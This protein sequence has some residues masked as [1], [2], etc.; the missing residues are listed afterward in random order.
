MVKRFVFF[1]ALML[2]ALFVF[3]QSRPSTYSVVRRVAIAA[4]QQAVFDEL[5]D[6]HEWPRWS[7]WDA[8]DPNPKRTFSGPMKG[9][10]ATYAWDGNP[11]VGKGFMRIASVHAP[12]RVTYLVRF[13]APLDAEMHYEFTVVPKGAGTDVTWVFQGEHPVWAKVIG[14]FTELD[15]GV[16]NDMER[17]LWALKK[18]V[19]GGR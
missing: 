3:L 12:T 15:R 13:E 6:L 16:G 11:Q 7:P 4:P 9:E 1:G 18:L 5:D 17:G 19:E 2:V 10:G 8:L 14:L